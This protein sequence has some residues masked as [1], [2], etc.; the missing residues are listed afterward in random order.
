MGL[1]FLLRNEDHFDDLKRATRSEF[2][3][4]KPEGCPD[5]LPLYELVRGGYRQLAKKLSCHQV[6]RFLRVFSFL[7]FFRLIYVARNMGLLIAKMYMCF[8]GSNNAVSK[9]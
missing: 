1:Y 7:S 3:W 5:D 9:S 8:Y 2:K 4:E 6:C